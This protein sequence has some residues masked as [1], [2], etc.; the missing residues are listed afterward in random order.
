MFVI[1]FTS[2]DLPTNVPFTRSPAT[3]QWALYVVSAV[4]CV[5]VVLLLIAV[6]KLYQ[7]K[8]RYGRFIIVDDPIEKLDPEKPLI[9][10]TAKLWY[11][12]EWEFL[13]SGIH[14][15][16]SFCYHFNTESIVTAGCTV[17]TSL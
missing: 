11:D 13:A 2:T 8:K 15:G 10:Q 4:S 17:Y 5:L 14:L 7:N 1:T 3:S 6:I 16:N 12:N 9:E